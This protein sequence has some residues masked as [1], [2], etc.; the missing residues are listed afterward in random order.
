MEPSLA[1]VEPTT[2]WFLV[3]FISA[4]LWHDSQV[5]NHFL[6]LYKQK[7]KPKIVLI[8]LSVLFP[9]MEQYAGKGP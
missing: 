2:S 3:G 9:S 1:A 5:F 7:A 6:K 4:A 8:L